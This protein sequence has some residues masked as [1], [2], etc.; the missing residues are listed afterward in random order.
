MTPMHHSGKDDAIDI[1]E[2]FL[3]WFALLGGLCGQRGTNCTRFAVRRNAQVFYFSTIIRDPIG[4]S[5]QLLAE[6]LRRGVAKF[7]E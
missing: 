3:E 5:M 6:F 1:G 4:Q 7:T 2:N